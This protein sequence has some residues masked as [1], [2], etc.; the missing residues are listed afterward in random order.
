MRANVVEGTKSIL[1]EHRLSPNFNLVLYKFNLNIY[2]KR[3]G[4][5]EPEEVQRAPLSPDFP[6]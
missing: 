2:K 5:K 3:R 6:Y 1:K 4:Q